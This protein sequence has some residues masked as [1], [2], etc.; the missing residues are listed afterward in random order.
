M[1]GEENLEVA[2]SSPNSEAAR[3]Q[4]PQQSDGLLQL[5]GSAGGSSGPSAP[6]EAPETKTIYSLN[7][8]DQGAS[9]NLG[10]PMEVKAPQQPDQ[11]EGGEA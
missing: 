7:P 8:F 5:S 11:P 9:R 3:P 6:A 2:A 1:L 4:P 10:A